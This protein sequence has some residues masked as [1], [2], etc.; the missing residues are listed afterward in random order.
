M[1]F[2]G[3]SFA[4]IDLPAVPLLIGGV[5]L[6]YVIYRVIQSRYQTWQQRHH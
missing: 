3:I 1:T 6:A 2:S 4:D 5:P